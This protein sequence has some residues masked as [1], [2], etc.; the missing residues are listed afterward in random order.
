MLQVVPARSLLRRT[1][2]HLRSDLLPDP[3]QIVDGARID[4][5]QVGTGTAAA[6]RHDTDRLHAA[7]GALHHHR[8]ATVAL[9]M[10]ESARRAFINSS[11]LCTLALVRLSDLA[12][13][14]HAIVIAAAHHVVCDP[15]LAVARAQAVALAPDGHDHL[16]EHLRHRF[17]LPDATPARDHGQ[18]ALKIGLV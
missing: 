5:G 7:G 1:H 6:P 13:V 16:P 12:A 8:S 14:F 15:L 11:F 17:T 4:A 3:G 10:D 9:Q 18:R 2:A